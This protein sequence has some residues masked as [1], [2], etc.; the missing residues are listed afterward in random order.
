M[1]AFPAFIPLRGRR[2]I[3]AGT[4]E[5]AEA[6]ARLLEGSP[7][8]VVRLTGP[9]AFDPASY[10]GAAAGVGAS[11]PFK[12]PHPLPVG[13]G[14]IVGLDLDACR[15]RVV[16]DDHFAQR[17]VRKLA[18]GKQLD[19]LPQRVRHARQLLGLVHVALEHR[20]RLDAL[21]RHRGKRVHLVDAHR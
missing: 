15:M 20:R 1:D 17:P 14:R 6:K 10:A 13:D 9:A 2:V 5:G 7:A 11:E 19:R 12:A 18:V 16:L 21:H 8:E 3:L 4:G